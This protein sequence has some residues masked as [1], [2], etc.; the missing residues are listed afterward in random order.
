MRSKNAVDFALVVALLLK[1]RLHV[2]YDLAGIFL[3]TRGVDRPVIII[4]GVGRVA[5]G[6][7]PV[8]IVPVVPTAEDEHDV[9]V[10]MRLPPPLIMPLRMIVVENYVLGAFPIVALIVLIELDCFVLGVDLVRLKIE[11]LLLEVLIYTHVGL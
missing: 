10:M 5:P 4:R 1:R 3:R 11:V 8:V 6:R 7:V 9:I 2:G